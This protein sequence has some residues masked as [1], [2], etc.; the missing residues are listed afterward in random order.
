[1]G[2]RGRSELEATEPEKKS[3]VDV[4]LSSQ[5]HAIEDTNGHPYG[6]KPWGN[7]M[8]NEDGPNLRE[9][10]LGNLQAL[11][12]ETLLF[13]LS[14]MSARDLCTLG[15]VSRAL[16]VFSHHS[17]L[18]RTLTLK[19]LGGE[20]QYNGNWKDT[21]AS[22]KAS[23]K[24]CQHRPIEI[25]GFYSDVL[26]DP[27]MR[28]TIDFDPSWLEVENIDRRSNLSVAV[29]P[30]SRKYFLLSTSGISSLF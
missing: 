13:V 21:Y 1:M 29:G 16:Y 10:S 27:W 8:L 22:H 28:A 6:V 17:D 2:K 18:W 19:D 7:Y 20:F 3:S 12:D 15:Q 30:H 4:N 9:T 23:G 25:Q 24:Y 14:T 26:Y 11:T 5:K